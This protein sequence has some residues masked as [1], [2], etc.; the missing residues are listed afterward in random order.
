[1]T[2]FHPTGELL[3]EIDRLLDAPDAEDTGLTV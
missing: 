3:G 2:W 1:M